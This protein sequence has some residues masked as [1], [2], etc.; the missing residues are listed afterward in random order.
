MV[1]VGI[2]MLAGVAVTILLMLVFLGV[3]V[4]WDVAL[5]LRDVAEKIDSLE[6]DVDSDLDTINGTLTRIH[7]SMRGEGR[8]R[9]AGRN[10]ATADGRGAVAD[11]QPQSQPARTATP[12]VAPSGVGTPTASTGQS[13]V[14]GLQAAQPSPEGVVGQVQLAN[15]RTGRN[16]SDAAA[17]AGASSAAGPSGGGDARA[18][19]G[20]DARTVA[21][22]E[23]GPDG[24]DDP[25]SDE[26]DAD[27]TTGESEAAAEP[28]DTAADSGT[29]DEAGREDDAGEEHDDADAEQT[30]EKSQESDADEAEADDDHGDATDD[31]SDADAVDADETTARDEANA[32]EAAARDD[33]D[34]EAGDVEAGTDTTDT[35]AEAGDVEAGEEALD[36]SVAQ[37][38]DDEGEPTADAFEPDD[39]ATEA[40]R[41]FG[42]D[43]R[44]NRGLG[45]SHDL[46]TGT[47]GD[48][49]AGRFE[50]S[51]DEPWYATRFESHPRSTG[52]I[53]Q[54]TE[55]SPDEDPGTG[56]DAAANAPPLADFDDESVG[57]GDLVAAD[58]TG[59]T[60]A[61]EPPAEP[62]EEG[63]DTEP[64]DVADSDGLKDAS[65]FADSADTVAPVV[66]SDSEQDET[67][68]GPSSRDDTESHTDAET[69]AAAVLQ[70]SE[71]DGPEGEDGD[72]EDGSTAPDTD[73]DDAASVDADGTELDTAGS[74]DTDGG[75]DALG[76]A[77]PE[78]GE[79][80]GVGDLVEQE[81][82][83]LT[84][85]VGGTSISPDVSSL[86]LTQGA[87]ELDDTEYTFP[88]SGEV[89]GLIASAENEVARL[90]LVPDGGTEFSGSSEQLL[91]YQFR[92][93]LGREGSEHAELRVD[94]DGVVAVE[95]PGATGDALDS[96]AD[97][98]IQITD[99]TL[100]LARSEE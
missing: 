39:S 55:P 89:Y 44:T 26:P 79:P 17:P 19:D 54:T 88:L 73:S 4:M 86:P 27:S 69:V 53:A 61:D 37:L 36:G 71:S 58:E 15:G 45:P 67:N 34:T 10:G 74:V 50:T 97:A 83:T 96:W 16:G 47:D 25:S 94:D 7:D 14:R 31:G 42:Q 8:G 1:E 13:T 98:L 29:E 68:A 81:L 38:L 70:E 63:A 57:M 41:T 46:F 18:A 23:L 60:A 30:G 62:G 11:R 64:D 80:V 43:A 33:A 49:G 2:Q 78:T 76:P 56:E 48:D 20:L 100:Y 21:L 99:R 93:Y 84:Q 3:V 5:A 90:E 22:D 87:E 52:A 66:G 40:V 72:H 75:A 9:T 91:R 95:I 24:P 35:D 77:G 6:D 82:T 85:E 65:V 32:D 28:G 59:D 12:N 92:N 51:A